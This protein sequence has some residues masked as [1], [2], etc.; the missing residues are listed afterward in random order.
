MRNAILRFSDFRFITKLTCEIGKQTR[1]L[2]N[3]GE[4]MAEKCESRRK[5]RPAFYLQAIFAAVIFTASQRYVTCPLLSS[6]AAKH[7]KM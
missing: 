3:T 4:K 6:H 5:L 7:S 1:K 2:A